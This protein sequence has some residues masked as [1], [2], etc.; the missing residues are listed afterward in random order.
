MGFLSVQVGHIWPF[1]TSCCQGDSKPCLDTANPRILKRAVAWGK[2]LFLI[3]HGLNCEALITQECLSTHH[4]LFLM[5]N[6]KGYTPSP[7]Q[8]REL[9]SDLSHSLMLSINLI[10]FFDKENK[11]GKMDFEIWKNYLEF[12]KEKGKSQCDSA[13]SL[14]KRK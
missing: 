4:I 5:S 13:R 10:S 9:I 7:K 12:E 3:T 6:T 8:P 2:H 14:R 11:L 1:A